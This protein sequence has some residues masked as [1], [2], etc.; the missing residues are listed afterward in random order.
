MAS[1]WWSLKDPELLKRRLLVMR[2]VDS[3]S[4]CWIW[5]GPIDNHGYGRI[6]V[7]GVKIR[8]HRLS[9]KLF[10][11]SE[12]I[13]NLQTCHRCNHRLCFN[14]EHLYSGTQSD[15]TNDSV[16]A[17]THNQASKMF[18]PRGHEYTEENTY[19]SPNFP[20]KRRCRACRSLLR[21][22]QHLLTDKENQ[23]N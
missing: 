9:H 13:D 11:A 18:C 12:F 8:V 10:K 16:K 5:T 22:L 14:P 19:K 3:T 4:D 17:G 7:D 2:R 6:R 1:S 21:K 23:T 20:N 15:N